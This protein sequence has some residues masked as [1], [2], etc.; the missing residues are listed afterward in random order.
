LNGPVANFGG[1]VAAGDRQQLFRLPRG[2]QGQIA[3]QQDADRAFRAS[4]LRMTRTWL[5]TSPSAM[6]ACA[7]WIHALAFRGLSGDSGGVF[8]QLAAQFAV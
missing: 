4:A 2:H 5:S 1:A 8:F 6:N 7:A 3:V